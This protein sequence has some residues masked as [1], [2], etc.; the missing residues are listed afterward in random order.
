MNIIEQI[1]KGIKRLL[2]GS[3]SHFV[4]R[5]G[6]GAFRGVSFVE[7]YRERVEYPIKILGIQFVG[8]NQCLGEFRIIV[9]GVKVFPFAETNPIEVGV[10]RNFVVPIE[11]A[12]G[13]LLEVEVRSSNPRERG[14]IIMDELDVVEMR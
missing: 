8:Q 7:I 2:F 9:D 14:V 11:V 3:T 13:S 10:L 6:S 5:Q 12:T 1:Y 4:I